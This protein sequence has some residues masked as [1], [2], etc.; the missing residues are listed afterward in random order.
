[1]QMELYLQET[2]PQN[3]QSQINQSI[4]HTEIQEFYTK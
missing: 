1:M 3:S 2:F 4:K